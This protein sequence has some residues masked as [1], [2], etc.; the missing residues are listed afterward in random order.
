MALDPRIIEAANA[1]AAQLITI[2]GGIVIALVAVLGTYGLYLVRQKLGI[3]KDDQATQRIETT[4]RNGLQAGAQNVGASMAAGVKVTN[5]LQSVIDFAHS[6]AQGKI[7][8]DLARLKVD[9]ASLMTR[10]AARADPV[11]VE[12]QV[13]AALNLQQLPRT[14][15]LR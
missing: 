6:Y 5:P 9:P 3:A 2:V 1:Q 15:P 14:P 13:T 7:A 12:K 8:P 11:T 4:I 10:V